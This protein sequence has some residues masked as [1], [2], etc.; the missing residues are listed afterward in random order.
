MPVLRPEL[1][2]I[3]P[4]RDLPA[5][6]RRCLESVRRETS[7]PY[8]VL[9]VDNG[10]AAPTR[11]LLAGLARRWPA[12]RVLREGLNDGFAASVN[13]GMRAA[14]GRV[15][16][17]LNNDAV[18]T[19]E[20]DARLARCLDSD[21]AAGAA[22]PVTNDPRCGAG[23]AAGHRVPER[24]LPRFARAWSRLYDGQREEVRQLTGFCLALKREALE[25]VGLLDER[26]AWGEEDDDYSFR[27]L[28]AGWKLLLARDVF[29]HHDGGATRSRLPR[30]VRERLR[31][32]NE[33]LL[34]D[35][36]LTKTAEIRRYLR[37]GWRK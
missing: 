35:K 14:R 9:V 5:A 33:R 12:L 13:R 30:G 20:W 6:T 34:F 37:T 27:L 29:V 23:R 24:E 7:L 10:S 15:L 31:R 1:S 19:P 17:W 8:E 3:V 4:V 36:W 22:G 28:Q 21:P 16:V 11:R 32:R 18:V 2:V 25:R 26:F